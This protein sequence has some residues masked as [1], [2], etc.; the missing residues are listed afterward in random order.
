[1]MSPLPNPH[2]TLYNVIQRGKNHQ[3]Q[4]GHS[5]QLIDKYSR[6]SFLQKRRDFLNC[7]T[8]CEE[9]SCDITK[10]LFVNNTDFSERYDRYRH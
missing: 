9:V 8:K 7:Y 1:M 4:I 6:V 3:R 5:L 10:N 2:E